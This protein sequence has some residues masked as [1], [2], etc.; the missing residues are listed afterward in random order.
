MTGIV[1]ACPKSLTQKEI[2]RTDLARLVSRG[3]AYRTAV[4]Q[5][6]HQVTDERDSLV[7]V[8]RLAL[9]Q[10]PDL[11]ELEHNHNNRMRAT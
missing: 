1:V 6:G 7:A 8:D 10:C 2:R 9:V 3:V 4:R 11:A 5:F